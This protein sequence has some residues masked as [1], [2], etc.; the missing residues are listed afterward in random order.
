VGKGSTFT[1]RIPLVY[2]EGNH[3]PRS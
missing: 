1:L 2:G 3:E